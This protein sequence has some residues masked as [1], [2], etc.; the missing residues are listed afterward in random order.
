M[1][2]TGVDF[3]CLWGDAAR[4]FGTDAQLVRNFRCRKGGAAPWQLLRARPNAT[5]GALPDSP[6]ITGLNW[7][8]VD[9]SE[10]EITT[11]L[12]RGASF[13]GKLTFEGSVQIDGEFRGE[14][15]T[16]GRLIIGAHARVHAQVT[17]GEVVVEGELKGDVVASEGLEIR[18]SAR[19]YGQL[20]AREGAAMYEAGDY[21]AAL[22][23][24]DVA[25]TFAP[26]DRRLELRKW[27]VLRSNTGSIVAVFG[28][29]FFALGIGALHIFSRPKKVHFGGT[30]KHYGADRADQERG[31]G[32]EA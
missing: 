8:E 9:M 26:Q 30:F 22:A 10:Q 3:G 1:R 18:S 14:I 29:M 32:E 24:F 17:A 2:Q 25:A 7:T 4:A 6:D 12:G 27:A 11:I 28:V 5:L 19:V 23:H 31:L 21:G 13:D 16:S 15:E 20:S